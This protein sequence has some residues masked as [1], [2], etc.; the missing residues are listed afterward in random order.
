MVE[1]SVTIGHLSTTYHT[2]FIL[3]G[4]QSLQKD[5]GRDISWKLFGTGPAMVRAF[6]KGELDIGY[7]GLPPAII[8]IDKGAPIKCVA[9]GHVEGTIMVSRA[10][11]ESISS[12][13]GNIG[14][15]LD[16]FK[17]KVIGTPSRGSIH[18][19]II[20]YYLEKHNLRDVIEL[21]NYKQA[22][23]IALD[24]QQ[25][26]LDGGV[27]TPALAV[28]AKTLLDTCLIIPAN[29]LIPNNPS[30]GIFF[31]EKLIQN[32]PEIGKIFLKHH[33]KASQ[34]LR[35]SKERAASIICNS[36]EVLQNNEKYVKDVLEISSK[37][38]IALSE[39]YLHS[40][41]FFI[42]ILYELGYI[43]KK[44]TVEEFC[45]FNFIE[46]IHPEEQHY[47]L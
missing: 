28:Y 11:Y 18:D 30:Y 19:V 36:M 5:M 23:L 45:D 34:L 6:S 26:I 4:N 24:M 29:Y 9:G 27:G 8:G 35:K 31:S 46:E 20:N 43:Q 47:Y 1:N 21:S 12:L 2:N 16:Q 13:N 10:G 41:Q 32:N 7:M 15:V 44:H 33:K 3:M 37:Y 42:N 14:E 39:E 17:G 40:T 25:G 22:E 38:C